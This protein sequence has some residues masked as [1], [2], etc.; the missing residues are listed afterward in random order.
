VGCTANITATSETVSDQV[1]ALVR[2]P[3]STIEVTPATFTL[4]IS[5]TGAPTAQGFTAILKAADG[6]ELNYV[7][8]TWAP[9]VGNMISLN[10]TS[11]ESVTA[12]VQATT[13]TVNLVA[14]VTSQGKSGQAV[15]TIN[16]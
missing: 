16:P 12:T 1:I 11:G 3:I 10:A 9:S 7:V 6:T 5:G 8:P 2:K 15:I 14:S 4:S 13:G